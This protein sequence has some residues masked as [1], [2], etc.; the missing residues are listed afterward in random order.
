LQVPTSGS[1]RFDGLD[2]LAQPEAM[3]ATLGYLPQD[4]GV[5]PRVSAEDL[6]DA[7]C[8]AQGRGRPRRAAR[9]GRRPC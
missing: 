7:P 2:V 6:L 1:I 3:R 5:Y 9:H 8:R 4:F